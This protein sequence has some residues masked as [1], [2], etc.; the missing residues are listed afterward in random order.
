MP[1]A[2]YGS[3]SS[4]E[5]RTQIEKAQQQPEKWAIYL[6]QG[7]SGQ[8]TP[9]QNRLFRTIL[10]KLAQ[11]QGRSVEYWHD[12]LVKRFLGFDDVVTE[13]GYIRKILPSTS[14]L[15]VTEFSEF[16]NACLVFAA[17]NQVT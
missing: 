1:V 3:L 10:R 14:E 13:D 12:F 9:A 11:Q 4:A 2:L 17:E 8:R 16:L 6:V 15:T 7:T 5:V